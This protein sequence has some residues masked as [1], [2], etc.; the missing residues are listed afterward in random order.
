MWAQTPGHVQPTAGAAQIVVFQFELPWELPL[1]LVA[2][3]HARHF[4][5][6]ELH[7]LVRVVVDVGLQLRVAAV[8]SDIRLCR[9]AARPL[10]HDHGW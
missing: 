9:L 2:H 5:A 10:Q 7:T 3:S 8:G 6:A 4:A 1:A